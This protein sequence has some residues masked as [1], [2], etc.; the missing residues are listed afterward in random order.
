MNF[1]KLLGLAVVSALALTGCK[2][3]KKAE[4]P[5]AAPAPAAQAQKIKVGVMSGPEHTVAEKAAQIAKEKYGL[6]V[7]FV[8]F[9]DY[10]LPNTAVSKGDLDANAF[11]HK[12][13]LDKDSASK[14]L[15][16][17][18]IVGN[19]FV[20][21]LAGYSKK[22]KNVAELQDGAAVAVPNDPSNLARA[23][24]LLEKQDLI[25]LKDNTNLFSTSLDI[26]EN[27]KNL[28]IQEVD[29]SVAA[30]ALDDVDLAV[31]NNTYAGQVGLNATEHG[32]FVENKESPYVNLIV[33][34]KDNQASEAVQN[35]AKAYQTEEVFQEAQKHFKDGVVKGW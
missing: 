22:I 18:V 31:V 4:A 8:L 23:L 19:T 32:V 25:K 29:T 16:N 6:E 27:P 24:I 21:P 20:Y 30:K 14:G 13:Y 34:R 33:A 5:A 9:N 1:K 10:A 17:L 11:Q 2:E 7:E 3:E 15:D 12:P 26:V 28:K 35:F